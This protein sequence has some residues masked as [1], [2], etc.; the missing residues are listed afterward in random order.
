MLIKEWMSRPV[1]TIQSDDSFQTAAKL[2]QTRVI[3]MLPVLKKRELVGIITDGDIKKATPSDATTLDKFEMPSLLDSLKIES[4][5][6]KPVLTIHDNHTVD[7]AAAIMLENSISGMPVT[8]NAGKIEG[9]ITKSDIFR[10]LVSFTGASSKGQAF[11][12]KLEDKPGAIKNIMDRIRGRNGRLRSILTSYDEIEEGFKK[13]FF[14]TYDIEPAQFDS[15]VR[16]FHETGG[17]LYA[18]DPSRGFRMMYNQYCLYM[19]KKK[20]EVEA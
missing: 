16:S 11:I 12:F 1:I 19:Y 18:A 3:S 17:L 7:E 4:I 2:F 13:V 10:C 15:L 8:D 9:V 14:H 6:S 5:M 20:Q